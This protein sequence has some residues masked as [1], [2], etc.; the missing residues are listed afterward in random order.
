[1]TNQNANRG[2]KRA[3]CLMALTVVVSACDGSKNPVVPTGPA[4]DPLEAQLEKVRAAT[5]KYQDVAIALAD[6]FV[7]PPACASMAGQG[8]MGYHYTNAG[9][10]DG[11]VVA[12]EPE[13]LLYIPEADRLSLVAVEYFVPVVLDGVPYFGLT[14]PASLGA[15]PRLFGRNFDDPMAGHNPTMPWHWE[16]HAWIWRNNPAGTF[17]PW[18]PALSCP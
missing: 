3:V 1:M 12:E 7:R 10:V 5:A 4:P 18:N 11:R 6:G 2:M 14:A 16:L 17:A 13:I 15:T 8:A 9:R